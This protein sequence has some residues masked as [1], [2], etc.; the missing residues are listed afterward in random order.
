M[1]TSARAIGDVGRPRAEPVA[2]PRGHSLAIEAVSH[3][4][5]DFLA[6][7]NV[8]LA[9]E[10]GEII[11]LLGPSG[12]GK[13][14]LLRVIAGFLQQSA[15]EVRV[16]NQV[17]D[18]LPPGRRN[19]GIVFQN[20]AL[21]PHMTAAQNV[22]YGLE[23]RGQP[24][25][26]IRARVGECLEIVQMTHLADRLPRELSGG[27]Q[28]RVA[29][30]RALAI[31]PSILLLDEPFA[32]LDK[33]L[34]FDMQLE[35]KRL[36]RRFG[37]TAVLVTHDQGEAMSVADRMAVMNQGRVEQYAAPVD[38]YDTPE[39]LFVNGFV[40]SSNLL[41]GRILG[42]EAGAYRVE[43]DCG[44]TVVVASARHL[45][46]GQRVVVTARPEHMALSP[47]QQAG[48]WPVRL[49]MN[50]PLGSQ[51]VHDVETADGTA[52][53]V[54]SSRLESRPPEAGSDVFCGLAP[55]AKAQLFPEPA[56]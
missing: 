50:M 2:T 44:A 19:V 35:I 14:T 51:Y 38:V 10:P 39:T 32:A 27:Q 46:S 20:Y 54:S 18:H 3:R 56:A 17:I 12:C 26:R 6:V 43:L 45:A 36:Q 33:N 34:R 49:R 41:H 47:M 4:Y 15:G 22:A 9:V 21:F 40:G 28:Q 48:F 52:L 30:A 23:A 29:L 25:A 5:E 1:S 7:D 31:E 8:S 11:A 16:D 13:T 55:H 53:K 24:R 42:R 37:L